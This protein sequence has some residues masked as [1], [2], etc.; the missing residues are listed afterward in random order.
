MLSVYQGEQD[1]KS[2]RMTAKI[3]GRILA[4]AAIALC[5]ILFAAA[6]YL[7]RL[8]SLDVTAAIRIIGFSCL[9]SSAVTFL[10]SLYRSTGR[11]ALSLIF[12]VLD[13]FLFPTVLVFGLVY[14]LGL[15]ENGVWLAL[16][17]SEMLT[18]VVIAAVTKGD[19]LQTKHTAIPENKIY[20][21][22]LLNEEANI[23]ALNEEIEAF[24]C[25]NGIDNKK[26]YYILLCIEEIA[27]NIIKYGF[28][29]GKK[30]YIDIRI[31]AG[32]Q[33]LLNI[34]DDAVQFDSTARKD[35]DV[36]GSAQERDIG[37]LGIYLVKKVAVE[38]SYKRVIGFNN[39]HIVL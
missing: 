13:N 7:S 16:L 10:N 32:E 29:D 26:Q 3:S 12:T 20:Q 5:L 37:G 2:I 6:P 18:L 23:V 4:G 30:H 17:I 36:T 27:V 9:F 28:K 14:G 35:A 19:F 22:L 31:I 33:V 11:T 25:K 34:R 38:F 15:G 8:F 21:T 39:L 24:C 1:D